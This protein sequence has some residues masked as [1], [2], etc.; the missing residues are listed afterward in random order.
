MPPLNF[1]RII[2]FALVLL[3]LRIGVGFVA[4]GF[5]YD[6]GSATPLLWYSAEH[7]LDAGVTIAVFSIAARKMEGLPYV[8]AFL[9]VLLQESMGA[10]LLLLLNA[11]F[12]TSPFWWVEW[13]VLGASVLVGMQLGLQ[14]RARKG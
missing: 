1:V 10:A 4:G 5:S 13:L 8:H 14:W 3:V 12:P 6:E 11:P 9:I 7:V 2:R